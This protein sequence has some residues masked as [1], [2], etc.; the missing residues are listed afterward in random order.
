[1]FLEASCNRGAVCFA[2]ASARIH[3]DIDCR[4]R[5]LMLPERLANQSLHSI[6]AHRIADDSSRDRKP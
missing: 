2:R 4:Q 3:D 5:M 1:M 6:P